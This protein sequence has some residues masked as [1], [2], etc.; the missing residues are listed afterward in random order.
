MYWRLQIFKITGRDLWSYVCGSHQDICK[1]LKKTGVT[2]TKNKNIHQ[3]IRMEF[4]IE[5]GAL[6]IIKI[7]RRIKV[8]GIELPNQKNIRTLGEKEKYS[9]LGIL[10][11][12]TIRK[13]KYERKIAKEYLKR[14]RISWETKLCCR[15]AIK[16][17]NILDVLLVRY[18]GP[19]LKRIREELMQKR[20]ND[21]TIL[22]A[23]YPRDDRLYI[24]R[25]KKRNPF[26]LRIA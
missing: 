15:N 20:S 11:A 1:I 3:T 2:I 9:Y 25:R 24:S 19:F 18:S 10:E 21:K 22:P 13:S 17:I 16:E 5:K 7:E 14:T 23:L 6:L 26:A 8:E 4:R 12:D